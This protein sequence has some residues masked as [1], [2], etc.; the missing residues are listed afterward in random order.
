[1][2]KLQAAYK[3]IIRDHFIKQYT[4]HEIFANKIAEETISE[5]IVWDFGSCFKEVPA[6]LLP[7]L[8]DVAI[9]SLQYYQ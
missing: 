1:L 3:W 8:P 7:P 5:A 2:Q 4:C 6:K 9:E